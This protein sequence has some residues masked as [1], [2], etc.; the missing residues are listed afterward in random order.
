MGGVLAGHDYNEV[1]LSKKR[2]EMAVKIGVDLFVEKNLFR[3]F[4]LLGKG[5][6]FV[7]LKE[8][9]REWYLPK[10]EWIKT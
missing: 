8:K 3:Y 10:F 4:R 7:I 9:L 5:R 2:K 6:T 1:Q